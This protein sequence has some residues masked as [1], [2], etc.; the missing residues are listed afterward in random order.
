MRF[1]YAGLVLWDCPKNPDLIFNY[2]F[3]MQKTCQKL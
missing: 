3:P 2:C 1:A